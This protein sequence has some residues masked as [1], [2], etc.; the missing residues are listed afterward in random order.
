MHKTLQRQ[1]TRNLTRRLAVLGLVGSLGTGLAQTT[2]TWWDYYTDGTSNEV[3]NNYITAYEAEHPDVKIERTTI[4]FGDLKAR[5]IQAAATN[6]MP[7]IVIIDNPDHQAMAAQGALADL[8]PY[9]SAWD[10]NGQYYDGPWS[11]TIYDD[12]NYGVPFGSNAT[13]LYYNVEALDEAGI[14]PPKTWDD[15]RSA[16]Q[17]LTTADRAG[18]CLSLVN[19]EEGTF[20]YL[21]FLW[22]NGG[23][24]PDLGG[25]ANIEALAFLN[26][27]M[28][29]DGSIPKGAL[30][31]AQGDTNNQ[32]MAGKCAMQIN[33]PWQ[34]PSLTAADLSFTW[35]VTDWPNNGTPTSILG[36]ENFAAGNGPN[37][38][39]A[40]D[41]IKF[42]ADPKNL[43]PA[44]EASGYITSRKDLADAP[45]FT[46]DPV[47]VV[48]AKQVSVAKARAYG[49]NY[50]E[51]S[52]E[53]MNMVQGVLAGGVN[54]EDAAQATA[55]T[56]QPLLP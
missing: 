56:V 22:G 4:G 18:F 52:A 39:A 36:G 8:T 42:A 12:K 16:A 1:L 45:I 26:A 35:N 48:F 13:A 44:Y 6:S 50:P 2:L 25:D 24:I 15:L 51:I 41:V 23:D 19:T 55:D 37:A 11:S 47:I 9:I 38:E 31:W 21:P 40:W 33:G 43:L 17:T 10:G 20:T 14:E 53:I 5:I 46:E 7:D 29:E 28:N 30:N 32:F 49:P 34:I 27:M 3:M 54:P